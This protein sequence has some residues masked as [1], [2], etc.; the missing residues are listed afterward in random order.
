VSEL[1][2]VETLSLRVERHNQNALA[3]A[4][5]LKTQPNVSWVDYPGLPE[6]EY[7]Q[8][9]L[10]Q[11][12]KNHFG[13]VLSFGVKGDPARGGEV[14]DALKLASN[15]ANVGDAK[16]VSDVGKPAENSSSFIPFR[17]PTRS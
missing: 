9:A 6:H 17:L 4:N 16:T 5:W 13:G 12:R 11:F 8:I 7:H 2:P 15:L 10:R 14:V 3:L 1:T